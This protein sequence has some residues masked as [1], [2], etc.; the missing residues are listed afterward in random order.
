MID[1]FTFIKLINYLNP[2]MLYLDFNL[3]FTLFL[4]EISLT[5]S[6]FH[7]LVSF[8]LI[9]PFPLNLLSSRMIFKVPQLAVGL[10]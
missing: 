9:V 4:V 3:P 10:K 5:L 7:N 2:N 6:V 1:I 8:T